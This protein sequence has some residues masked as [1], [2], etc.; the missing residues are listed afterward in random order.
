LERAQE[1]HRPKD[2]PFKIQELEWPGAAL[3]RVRGIRIGNRNQHRDLEKA[4]VHRPRDT[5]QSRT[6]VAGGQRLEVAKGLE[7]G[8]E[9]SSVLQYDFL[10]R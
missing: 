2:T 8:T 4:Q 10:M 9:T 3:G 6:G 1:V 5:D 7:L